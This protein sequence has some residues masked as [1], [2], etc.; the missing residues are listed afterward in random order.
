MAINIQS[1]S[2]LSE[3]P[4]HDLDSNEFLKATGSWVYDC[5]SRLLDAKDLFRDVIESP[6]RDIDSHEN[7]HDT[8]IESKYCTIK[9]TGVFFEKVNKQNGFSILHCNMRSLSKNV[10]LLQDILLTTKET[11]D[12]IAIS[13]T[14][15]NENSRHNITLPGYVFLHTNS[16]TS[17]GGVGLYISNELQFI[18]RRD[19]ELSTDGIESCWVELIRKRQKNILIGCVYRHPSND[20]DTFFE[21]LKNKLEN[22]N[23]KGHEVIVVGDMN[24]NFLKY[25]DDNKTSE[26]LDMLLNLGFMPLITKATRITD[27]TSTLID[28]I[29]TNTPQKILKAGICLADV[30]D[31]LPVFCTVANKLPVTNEIKYFRDYSTFDNELF[32]K[33]ISETDFTSFITD[34]INESMSAIVKTFQHISDK[35]APM[36]KTTQQKRRQLKKPWIT[37]AILT[38]IKRR[39]RLFKT[40]ILN[41]DPAKTKEY[42]TYNNKLNK[43]KEAA[44]KNYYRA[45]FDF[46]KDNLKTTWKLIGTIINRK[47]TTSQTSITKLIYNNKC[48]IDRASICHQLNS[49]YIN[50]GHNLAE[51]LP[52]HD[53]NPTRYI[54]KSFANSFMFR[55]IYTHEVY[56]AIMGLKLDKSTIGI[57]Q[58]CIKI[59]NSHICEAL[60]LIFNQSLLQGIVPDI[61]KISKVTPVDKGGEETDPTNFRP[62]STLSAL[63]QIFEKLVYKQL[64]N[65]IEKHDILFQFQFGFRKGRSTAQAITEITDN[66]RRAIDNNLYTCGIFLDFSKAFDTVNHKILIHKLNSYGIRGLPLAWFTSYLTNRQQYVALGNTESPKQTMTCGIPQGSV[67]GPLLFLIYIN[68]LPNCSKILTFRIFADDTNVFASTRDPKSLEALIN[69]ELKKVKEWCDINKLSINFSKTNYMIIKSPRKGNTNFNITLQNTDGSCHSLERKD[70]IKYLGVLIDESISWKYHISYICSKISQNNGIISKL[71]HY[72]S[73]HQ[74]KQMYYNLIYPYI[75]YAIL[76]WGSAYKTHLHKLQTKQ[77]TIARIMFFATSFGK[78]TESA[79]PLLNILD[80]LTVDNIYRLHA[81]KFTHLWHKGQ[82]PSLFNNFFQYATDVHNYNTRYAAKQNLYKSRVRTNTGKQM[83]SNMAIDLW[84]DIPS[85]LKDLNTFSF[86]KKIKYNLLSE[87]HS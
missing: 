12:I 39:Q 25:N 50:V 21:N 85:H 55:G 34:D 51:K 76:A 37:N 7:A 24:I 16:Q 81:L 57:P 87:Q 65:F 22:L 4:F 56:D 1:S 73:I 11:P 62:I 66:L 47:K 23:D 31:H 74:L 33:E 71:R 79:L 84:H 15:L 13:E 80:L 63:T 49:H 28:H 2:M 29:Y 30:S 82:L 14:K 20:R 44:K 69:S 83:I 35:H 61:L 8:F 3:L 6:E 72:L 10:S 59:A 45:Q 75:S 9:Q 67:L 40:H 27:H 42:K 5:S 54:R 70:H 41:K 86:S 64:I 77:N 52:Q 43:I 38:S 53:T 18:R 46:H 78:N 17:A 68:D 32:I 26:Y 60:T 58:R 48:Y 36:R 19:L